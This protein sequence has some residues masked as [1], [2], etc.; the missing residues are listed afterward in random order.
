M[1]QLFLGFSMFLIAAAA[2]L[3]GLLFSLSVQQRWGELGL[4]LAVG[5]GRKKVRRLLLAQG[6]ILAAIGCAI[7]VAGGIAYARAIIWGLGTFWSGAVGDAHL[8][9]HQSALSLLIGAAGA[10]AIAM[11]TMWLGLRN[12]FKRTPHELLGG[13]DEGLPSS[14]P[15]R[16]RP[17]TGK[18]SL[19][20]AVVTLLGAAALAAISGGAGAQAGSE[21]FFAS[22]A[23]FLV[24]CLSAVRWLFASAG[25]HKMHSAHPDAPRRL[26]LLRLAL[27]NM[28]RRRGRSLATVTLLACGC[29]MIVAV[30]AFRPS[31]D[32]LSAPDGP[33]GG[34][35]LLAQSTLPIKRDFTTDAG[36]KS[37]G[38]NPQAL[39]HLE[40]LPLRVNGGDD[41]SCLN[42][43]RPQRPRLLGAPAEQ[44]Q[45]RGAFHFVKELAPGQGWSALR[46]P[47]KDDEVPAVGDVNTVTWALGKD[48]GQ[49]IQ[50]TDEHGKPLTIRIVGVIAN[51]ILQGG[52]IIDEDAF[53]RIFPSQGGH[54]MLLIQ[55]PLDQANHVAARFSK[56]FSDAGLEVTPAAR[57]L[58]QFNAVENAFLSIFQALGGLGMVLG[59]AGLAVVVLRNVME[60]RGEL[61]LLHAVGFSKARLVKLILLEHWGLLAA[62]LAAGTVS[63]LVAVAPMAIAQ[64]RQLPIAWLCVALGFIWASS[65]A[66]VYLATRMALAGDLMPALRSE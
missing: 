56:A 55:T 7:G 47:L 36:T 58:A 10:L 34:F 13:F 63:A 32:G 59:S 20:L 65:I 46:L 50:Y 43:N 39:A 5:L 62:G 25:R 18:V 48:V 24:A 2:L 4:L 17:R 38:L 54:Q 9:F 29:F 1:G 15:N 57:R 64:G 42:L 27:T 53:T 3:T 52:L 51:S 30:A 33:S 6:A 49:T 37:I 40:I 14:S 11:L 44:L 12:A 19:C 66:W 26:T 28:V 23:L 8:Q 45:R 60:R 16:A 41:A 31:T 35:N 61:A 21:I 22:A